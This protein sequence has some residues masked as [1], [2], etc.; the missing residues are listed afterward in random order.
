MY[1]VIYK[2]K[3]S[4]IPDVKLQFQLKSL[5]CEQNRILYSILYTVHQLVQI[6]VYI[7]IYTTKTWHTVVITVHYKPTLK[8]GW[9]NYAKLLFSKILINY[10]VVASILIGLKRALFI[11][12]LTAAFW[13]CQLNHVPTA[14]IK[15]SFFVIS[16]RITRNHV[17]NLFFVVMKTFYYI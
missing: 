10:I 12:K 4:S 1:S 16:V 5:F 17:L 3:T 7:N 8:D 15:M 2:E 13:A 9:F 11:V 14:E 6:W